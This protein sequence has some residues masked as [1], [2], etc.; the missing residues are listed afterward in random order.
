MDSP[1]SQK[2]LKMAGFVPVAVIAVLAGLLALIDF[3]GPV[4][5]PPYLALILQIV[6]VFC[7]GILLAIVSA[8][9]YLLFGSLNTLLVGIA[10]MASGTML[11][12]AQYSITPSSGL[13]FTVNQAVTIG[14]MGILISSF[15]L[16]ISAILLFIPR[17]R[18]PSDVSR[19]L[20]LGVSIPIVI[21]LMV[22]VITAALFGV[23]PVFFTDGVSTVWRQIVLASSG[24]LLA[25][26][27][28]LFGWAYIRSRSSLLYW[29]SLGII[30][31]AVSL[32]GLVF[33][34][35]IGD[36]MNWLGRLGLYFSGLFFILAVLD[37]SSGQK[38]DSGVSKRWAD[39][40]RNDREQI[41]TLFDKMLNG[42]TYC[43]VITDE[44]GKPVDYTYL[45]VNLAFEKNHGLTITKGE[46]IGKKATQVLPGIENDPMDLIGRFGKVAQEMEQADFEVFSQLE[47]KWFHYSVYSPQKGYFVSTSEDITERKLAEIALIESEAK[48]RSL[49]ENLQES[50]ILR[51]LIYDEKGDI[52]DA[53]LVDANPA[54]LK[55]MGVSSLD[56]ARLA[57]SNKATATQMTAIGLNDVRWMKAEGK[58]VTEEIHNEGNG[59]DYLVTFAPLG[60][61]NVIVTGIDITDRRRMEEALRDTEHNFRTV[62]ENS[63]DGINMLDLT[64]GRYVFLSPAQMKLTGFDAKELQGISAEETYERVHPD[65]REAS[66]A[67]QRRI[68]AGE[69]WNEPVEYR[70]KV[71]SGEYRW[72]S[73]RRK[74]VRDDQG[75]PVYLVGVS[76]DITERKKA[77]EELKKS[78][79]TYRSIGELIPFGI[80]TADA[81]GLATYVSPSFCELVG[82]SEEEV[83]RLGWLDTLDQDTVDQTVSEWEKCVKTGEFWNRTHHIIGKDGQDHYVLSRGAPIRDDGNKILGWVG[84][85]INVTDQKRIEENLIRSNADLQQFAYL[86]SHD[87]QEPLRMMVSYISLLERK[88]KGQLD[89][90]AHEYIEN[91]L[92]GGARMR[93]LIDD[94]LEYSRVETKGKEFASVNMGEVL[95]DTLKV[96]RVP[97]EENRADIFVGP[98]PYIKA[99]GS[100]MLQLMQNLVGNAIK[101]RGSERPIVQV[102]AKQSGRDWTFS[103]KDNGIGLNT[104]YSDRIFQM[105]QRLHTQDRYPGTGVGLAIAKKIVERHGGRIWVESEEGNGA[106]FHFTIPRERN[107]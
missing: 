74:L 2:R 104:E 38:A 90:N 37:R 26:A 56:E 21:I 12:I 66:V 35:N 78:E 100:Q 17:E 79:K 76:R 20:I 101:F 70:W 36:P 18:L 10:P 84:V 60:K 83:L 89:T 58:P 19:K 94:L 99:D 69:E 6:F 29:Y 80:W 50:V 91:A 86:S 27:C 59:R 96:L 103:V 31:F 15:I 51:Q 24:A 13:A 102:T 95:E 34:V 23:L 22:G 85:N 72:F 62:L 87:L 25:V 41:A 9:A 4:F 5:D 61:D 28:G 42:F 97:I 73:D 55:V 16:F 8:R 81:R 32:I 48:Y 1:G 75:K 53:I 30:S 57:A 63:L 92:E 107:K 11:M 98:L 77:E 47:K 106:T 49:I 45:D 88:Y 43:K 46:I 39:A 93:Q 14:N 3:R 82:K 64:T 33:T 7:V 71:K 44:I 52:A 68:A 105:F 67:H 54:A 65:D 40:F